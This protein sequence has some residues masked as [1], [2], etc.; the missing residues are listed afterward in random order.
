[1]CISN[2]CLLL[3]TSI[4]FCGCTRVWLSI[5]PLKGIG[6]FPVVSDSEW[7]SYKHSCIGLVM[8]KKFCFKIVHLKSF[9]SVYYCFLLR[10]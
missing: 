7:S 1:M 5:Q 6:L 10:F 4:P 9:L 3:L 8:L 2:V